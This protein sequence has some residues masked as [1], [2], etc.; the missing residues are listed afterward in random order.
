MNA[1]RLIGTLALG[2]VVPICSVAQQQPPPPPKKV[3]TLTTEDVMRRG[4]DVETSDVVEESSGKKKSDAGAKASGE[5]G[6]KTEISSEEKAWRE[7][8]KQARQRADA[9]QRAAEEAELRVTDL[10]NRLSVSGLDQRD[11]NVILAEME[12]T[13]DTVKQLRAEAKQAKSDLENALD[14]GREKGYR[15]DAGP[16]E[17]PNESYYREKYA[18]LTKELDD[19][20]RRVQLYDDRVRDINQRITINSRTGDNYFIAKLQQDRDEAQ[21]SLQD[22]QASVE[23]AQQDIDALKE[24]ARTSGVPPG[25]FR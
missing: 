22:A 1:L 8:V 17:K 12:E 3:P 16:S 25:V 5:R 2:L 14:Q 18:K 6:D 20:Q 23:K 13:G 24:E 9:A 7:N 4:G 11:R 19:A 21:Q 10:R 15:E